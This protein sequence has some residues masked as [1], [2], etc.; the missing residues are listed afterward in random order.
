M[1][2]YIITEKVGNYYIERPVYMTLE[3][4]KKYKLK[5]D[6]LQYYKTKISATN[7]KKKGSAEAQKNL[8]PTYYVNNDF[9]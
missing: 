7:S 9:F 1:E 2:R 3:E 6:M 4:Y 5:R 8:L